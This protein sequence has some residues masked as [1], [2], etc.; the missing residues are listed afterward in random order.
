MTS[1][2]HDDPTAPRPGA[3]AF[4]ADE[5]LVATVTQ[6]VR[7]TLEQMYGEQLEP[8]VRAVLDGLGPVRVTSYLGVLVERQLRQLPTPRR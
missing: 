4:H 2:T 5:E 3:T 7:P 8:S 6:S 1:V